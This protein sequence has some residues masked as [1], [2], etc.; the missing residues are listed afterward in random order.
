MTRLI[1]VVIVL[2]LF[3][4]L[5][6]GEC[7]PES[8]GEWFQNGTVYYRCL[9]SQW[10]Y[11]NITE[12]CKKGKNDLTLTVTYGNDSFK[13]VEGGW[14]P[15]DYTVIGG[16]WVGKPE[17]RVW[18]NP[19]PIPTPPD[20]DLYRDNEAAQVEWFESHGKT[21]SSEMLDMEYEYTVDHS[22]YR[23]RLKIDSSYSEK[24]VECDST[25]SVSKEDCYED[26]MFS[27]EIDSKIYDG[28]TIDFREVPMNDSGRLSI[29]NAFDDKWSEWFK[30][31]DEPSKIEYGF[32]T[33]EAWSGE[34]C[35]IISDQT[36]DEKS[37]IAT[38]NIIVNTGAVWTVTNSNVTFNLT[39]DNQYYIAT[40][41]VGGVG[42]MEATNVKFNTT[43][44]DHD[45]TL[46]S[47]GF[48]F[49]TDCDGAV[50][51]FPTGHGID[52]QNYLNELKITRITNYGGAYSAFYNYGADFY[53]FDSIVPSGSTYHTYF[54]TTS[55]G[56]SF[57]ENSTYKPSSGSQSIILWLDCSDCSMEGGAGIMHSPQPF[58][59][60]NGAGDYVEMKGYF[61]IT[62]SFNAIY[63]TS[64]YYL[65]RS[66][67]F[68]AYSDA[69]NTINIGAGHEVNT[70][71]DGIL[72]ANI[73]TDADG[74]GT[75]WVD[76]NSSQIDGDK[77][78]NITVEGTAYRQLKAESPSVEY[79][80]LPTLD[81]IVLSEVSV[82]L[83]NTPPTITY[84]ETIAAK[85][86]VI[87]SNR[88]VTLEF[89]ATDVDG[90]GE[91][92]N[93]TA[94]VAFN[95][96]GETMRAN[97]SCYAETN[98]SISVNY[99]CIVQMQYWDVDGTWS[100]NVS[101]NDSSGA[102]ATN[103]VNV[104]TYNTLT[105][106]DLSGNNITFGVLSAGLSGQGASN[107]PLYILNQGNQDI[108]TVTLNATGLGGSG[109]IG[110]G[111][112]TV[113]ENDSTT[114]ETQLKNETAITLEWAN[115][116]RGEGTQ[117]PLYFFVDIPAGE[118]LLG[119]YIH[120]RIWEV[121]VS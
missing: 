118:G 42:G 41:D 97:F 34:T 19:S 11:V 37:I 93:S 116:T 105:A 100:I 88:S 86:P 78:F 62:A 21:I 50:D 24:A 75:V 65:N 90:M 92:I 115:V 72:K 58:L 12:T 68:C 112:F 76:F 64:D 7:P 6:V 71:I 83:A 17:T 27:A 111:N 106:M 82:V 79:S 81:G 98:S 4:E 107:D 95:K 69:A 13:C 47:R 120:R 54:Y 119:D 20:I 16:S 14:T 67:P 55:T 49:L 18:S 57:V 91:L 70:I 66:F 33:D 29:L 23:Y 85:D 30:M 28:K 121:E 36:D 89:T 8:E 45:F 96:S 63:D 3:I 9:S 87:N 5:G 74:C 40:Y 59:F 2:L 108:S 38:C 80:G 1:L 73:T 114:G 48:D 51:E 31:P 10:T 113:N 77:L 22:E 103:G 117:E 104:F 32:G 109:T 39:A 99:T 44:Y 101:V 110:A 94:F 26:L 25:L 43:N 102:E 61:N 53:L 35:S 56:Q 15:I 52:F 46:I 84:V 60:Y